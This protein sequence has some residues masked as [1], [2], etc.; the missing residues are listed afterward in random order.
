MTL[1]N[2]IVLGVHYIVTQELKQRAMVLVAAGLGED[3]H[4]R[5]LVAKLRGI[6]ADLNFELLN[7]I[8]GR[9]GDVGIEIHVHVVDTIKGV[10]IVEDALPPGRYCLARRD[11][12]LGERQ[13]VPQ[14]GKAHSHWAL[15]RPDSN[16]D[17]RSTVV[18]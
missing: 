10:V 14:K 5:A 1:V 16:I 8:N 4:L 17:V 2:C 6:D 13:L 9:K 12:L 18:R 11:R 3:I 15:T 7:R